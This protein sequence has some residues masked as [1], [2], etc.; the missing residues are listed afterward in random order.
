MSLRH[1]NHLSMWRLP[2]KNESVSSALISRKYWNCI[3]PFEILRKKR[4]TQ[5]LSLKCWYHF[6]YYIFI[7]VHSYKTNE[8]NFNIFTVFR[9]SSL[10]WKQSL[11]AW[12]IELMMELK[13]KEN[14]EKEKKISQTKE[15]STTI[16]NERGKNM[17]RCV[18]FVCLFFGRCTF[19]EVAHPFKWC[20][21]DC[22]WIYWQISS[23]WL[24]G[25]GTRWWLDALKGWWQP[26]CAFACLWWWTCLLHTLSP[27]PW[28]GFW[29]KGRVFY[30]LDDSCWPRAAMAQHLQENRKIP[31]K[32]EPMCKTE[33]WL[34]SQNR[35]TRPL[36]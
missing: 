3:S 20:A 18:F 10:I 7:Y 24:A 1:S 5:C 35:L 6:K 26:R 25:F 23:P 34:T 27:A 9:A 11:V 16:F 22:S 31:G 4:N 12:S 28:A 19:K 13:L 8:V 17:A 15:F 14:F 30:A 21:Y 33:L 32:C 36:I 29:C 2:F